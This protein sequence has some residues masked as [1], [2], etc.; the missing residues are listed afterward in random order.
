MQPRCIACEARA[1]RSETLYELIGEH[2]WRP[3]SQ[4]SQ[5]ELETV[6]WHCPT[7]WQR[8]KETALAGA[9]SARS[10]LAATVIEDAL[11]ERE[12]SPKGTE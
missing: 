11:R 10:L 6:E 12:K 2:G 3:L 5:V 7:C 4:E 9:P 8:Y 1:P